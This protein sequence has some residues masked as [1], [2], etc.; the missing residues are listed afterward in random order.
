VISQQR[1]QI[2]DKQVEWGLQAKAAGNEIHMDDLAAICQSKDERD[3]LTAKWETALHRNPQP[4][5]A[6][7]AKP[8]QKQE[9]K[10]YDFYAILPSLSLRCLKSTIGNY[11]EGVAYDNKNI[12]ATRALRKCLTYSQKIQRLS[13]KAIYTEEQVIRM[14]WKHYNAR[15]DH[16]EERGLN[17]RDS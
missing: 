11:V 15:H 5:P 13:G 17:G 1:T 14:F 12:V 7:A 6:P 4:S 9:D 16:N 2:L 3:V 8:V 10:P